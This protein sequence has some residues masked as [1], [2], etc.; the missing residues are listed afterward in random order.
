MPFGSFGI[1]VVVPDRLR[2]ASRGHYRSAALPVAIISLGRP[3]SWAG[4]LLFLMP[5]I[6]SL[7]P[8]P[9]GSTWISWL[10]TSLRCG[11]FTGSASGGSGSLTLDLAW[12]RS[13]FD[14]SGFVRIASEAGADSRAVDLTKRTHWQAVAIVRARV[15]FELGGIGVILESRSRP[16]C[17]DARCGFQRFLAER[18]DVGSVDPGRAGALRVGWPATPVGPHMQA[19]S[20]SGY[21]DPRLTRVMR[22]E[23]GPLDDFAI[24]LPTG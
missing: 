18:A 13:I 12:F 9:A 24:L 22:A 3:R 21:R 1:F 6:S 16:G 8:V 5:E 19:G 4:V 10:E 7:A 20:R 11:R 2:L 14:S 23:P 15:R 17:I